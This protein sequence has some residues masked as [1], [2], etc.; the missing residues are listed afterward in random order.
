MKMRVFLLCGGE[1]SRLAPF[2]QF[3]PKVLL[4]IGGRPML[5]WI[6]EKLRNENFR[7][8]VILTNTRFED[9][10]RYHIGAMEAFFG[11]KVN[12]VLSANSEDLGTAGELIRAGEEGLLP[13][14]AF[15]VYYGDILAK[16]SLTK[17]VQ[18]HG[19]HNPAATLA[20]AL[21]L[22]SEKGVV[23]LAGGIWVRALE[24][25]PLIPL[26]NWCGIGVFNPAILQHAKT[27]DDFSRDVIPRAL[28]AGAKVVAF[29]FK[30]P[31]LDI[32]SISAYQEACRMAKE[33]QIL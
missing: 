8:L 21:R 7:D 22:K 12:M 16:F 23:K 18:L 33:G 24:E 11:V 5:A 14:E 30:E 2:T 4:P 31:Y 20:V 1:G 13:D 29:T 17:M 3:T 6:V 9:Q 27:G 32:G 26:P 19:K 15:M 28:K 10:F 25:K